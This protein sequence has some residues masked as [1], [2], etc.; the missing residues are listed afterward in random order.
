MSAIYQQAKIAGQFL[1]YVLFAKSDFPAPLPLRLKMAFGGGFTVNEYYIFDLEHQD[2]REYLSELDWF[3]SRKINA[4][5]AAILNDKEK[6]QAAIEKLAPC[7]AML[8]VHRKGV[9]G[10]YSTGET[11]SGA[12]AVLDLLRAH[13][14]SILKPLAKGKG[15][16]IRRIR[17]EE[18]TFLI[19]DAPHTPDE[20]FGLLEKTGDFVLC[21]YIRQHDYAM[22]IYPDSV[23]TIRFLVIKDD[24]GT[25]VPAFAL[26]RFGRRGSGAVDNASQG[27]LLAKIDIKTGELSELSSIRAVFRSDTHPDTGAQVKGVRV[28]GWSMIRDEMLKVSAAFDQLQFIA[29]DIAVTPNG[30]SVIEGNASTGVNVIQ[31]WGGQRRQAFGRFL[32]EK[33]AIR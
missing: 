18:G 32:K 3:R 25:F 7:P 1:K 8:L 2:R 23:N 9:Y 26:Q 19:D 24:T 5:K 27:G 30:Y 13:P 33:G 15:R 20:L 10:D 14:D 6:F 4:G 16:G 17:F 11:L 22:T 12:D 31:L 28:P 29:W 21:A